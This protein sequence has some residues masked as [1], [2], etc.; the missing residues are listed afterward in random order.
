MQPAIGQNFVFQLPAA[1]SGIAKRQNAVFRPLT[2]GN[3]FKNINRGRHR[4]AGINV[5]G[6]LVG[7]V[8]GMQHEPATAFDR[9]AKMHLNVLNGRC[10]ARNTKLLKKLGEGDAINHTIDHK[11]HCTIFI[12]GTDID[13]TL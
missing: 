6:C 13:N 2:Q 9:A 5:Q 3:L 8:G 12:M 11:P 4:N 1:P 10:R 7:K